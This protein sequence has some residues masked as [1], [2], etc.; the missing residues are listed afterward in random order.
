MMGL[1]LQSESHFMYNA[2]LVGTLLGLVVRFFHFSKRSFTIGEIVIKQQR[3][4]IH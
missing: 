1:F 4:I 3:I 2:K